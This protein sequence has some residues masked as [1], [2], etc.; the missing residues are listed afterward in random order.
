M[1]PKRICLKF[2]NAGIR[3]D[4]GICGCFNC[5]E[6]GLELFVEGTWQAVCDE[7]GKRYAPELIEARRIVCKDPDFL[8]ETVSI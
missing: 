7:C 4:C 6:I 3:N 1:T 5:T 8:I 2:S